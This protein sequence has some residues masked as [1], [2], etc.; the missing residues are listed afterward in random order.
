MVGP[1]PLTPVTFGD[2]GVGSNHVLPT[3]RT[4]RFSSGLRGADFVTVSSFVE[5]SEEALGRFGTEVEAVAAVEGLPGR[6]RAS[7]ARRKSGGSE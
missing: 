6:A 3:M 1:G 5:G 7:E 4:A 2:Y